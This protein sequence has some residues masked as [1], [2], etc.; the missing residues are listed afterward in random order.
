MNILLG[1]YRPLK[2]EIFLNNV[3]K[4]DADFRSLISYV[5]QSVYIF[6]DT[7]KENITLG[8][9]DEIFDKKLDESLRYFAVIL[10]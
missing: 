9:H 4:T 7:I 8:D 10:L 2:G 5:P 1:L 3:K 6:D